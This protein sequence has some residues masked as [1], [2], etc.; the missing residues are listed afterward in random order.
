M[1]SV[2]IWRG[3]DSGRHTIYNRITGIVDTRKVFAFAKAY[4]HSA[5]LL[6]GT[7]AIRISLQILFIQ[8]EQCLISGVEG[9]V[10]LI[11]L[12]W[13]SR[14]KLR[15]AGLSEM[16]TVSKG[17]FSVHREEGIRQDYKIAI[18]IGLALWTASCM[19]TFPRSTVICE[20]SIARWTSI[21]QVMTVVLDI[22]ILTSAERCSEGLSKLNATIL[23]GVSIFTGMI[24]IVSL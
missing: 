19:A 18:L 21:F 8:N 11:F 23:S 10:P 7:V 2:C 9:L 13:K 4:G 16:R 6:L 1:G 22:C 12:A 20:T 5:V 14:R 17:S 15:R 24:C 3:R